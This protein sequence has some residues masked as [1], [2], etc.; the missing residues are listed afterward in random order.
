MLYSFVVGFAIHWHESAMGVHLSPW[1]A[2]L[3]PPSPSHPSGM[4]QCTGFECPISCIELGLQPSMVL[5]SPILF[6]F[7]ISCVFVFLSG[8]FPNP[9]SI[10]KALKFYEILGSSFLFS[11]FSYYSYM[12]FY[13]LINLGS[14]SRFSFYV[15]N[16][17]THCWICT[18][19]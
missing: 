8:H 4:S 16:S 3:T 12:I 7:L 11:P 10:L 15:F 1:P 17:H 9:F 13:I 5:K 6:W 18:T 14:I 2:P 19:V